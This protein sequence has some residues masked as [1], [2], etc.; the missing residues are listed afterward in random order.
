MSSK[1]GQGN[2]RKCLPCSKKDGKDIIVSGKS[3]NW[4]LE[5]KHKGLRIADV[6]FEVIGKNSL[7]NL[8]VITDKNNS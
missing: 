4:H 5:K 2:Y 3:V 7:A 1:H 6:P 8:E